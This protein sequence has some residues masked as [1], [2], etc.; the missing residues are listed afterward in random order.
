MR[1]IRVD[2]A[3]VSE[4]DKT[5]NFRVFLPEPERTRFKVACAKH[6]TTMSQ[7]A[8]ELIRAWLDAEENENSSTNKRKGD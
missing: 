6:R 3:V 2:R 7:K 8:L 4:E 5:V 1:L